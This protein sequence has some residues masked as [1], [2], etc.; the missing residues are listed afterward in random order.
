MEVLCEEIRD[1]PEIRKNLD[2]SGSREP[3]TLKRH[4][5]KK[6]QHNYKGKKKKP[7]VPDEPTIRR[8][9]NT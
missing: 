8:H 9:G 5:K 4:L 2:L 7:E 6:G 1:K 3:G